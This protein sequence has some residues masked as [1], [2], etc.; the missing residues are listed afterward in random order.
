MFY[1]NGKSCLAIL[2]AFMLAF[3]SASLPATAQSNDTDLL[4]EADIS[5]QWLRSEKQYIA[6]GNA[7]A[8]QR[9]MILKADV[10]TAHYIE[11]TQAGTADADEISI[12]HMIG[13][14]DAVFT[15]TGLVASADKIEYDLISEEITL[16]GGNPKI[17]NDRNTLTSSNSISYDRRSRLVVAVGK[18]ELVLANGRQLRGERI[19]A[20][21][22]DDETDFITITAKGNAEVYSP[23]DTGTR[24]GRAD[25]LIYNQITGI[26]DLTGN[27]MLKDKSNVMTGDTAVID[28]IAGTSTLSSNGGR[29]GGVFSR[30]K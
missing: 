17:D 1:E 26:A 5:L 15:R 10:I 19:E 25:H 22:N 7:M 4:V 24:E 9:D 28:T 20:V 29:V 16:T 27:V 13:M 14:K 12:S 30:K 11:E 6:T 8:K 23:D 21:L 3:F 2:A 18:A